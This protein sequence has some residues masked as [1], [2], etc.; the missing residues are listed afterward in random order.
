MTRV[1]VYIYEN[2][3]THTHKMSLSSF[4]S[5]SLPVLLKRNESSTTNTS[6]TVVHGSVC[7]GELSEVLSNHLRLDLY[8]DVLLSIVH[9]NNTSNHLRK[10]DDVTKMS[11]DSIGFLLI[12]VLTNLGILDGILD[13]VHQSDLLLLEAVVEFSTNSG[14][15]MRKKILVLFLHCHLNELIQLETSE[16]EFLEDTSF[17]SFSRLCFVL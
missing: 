14:S 16:G 2:T 3:H 7:N 12:S 8:G 4:S 10:N 9:S 1:C 6:L 5:Y 11:L 13:L 15:Q 17:T